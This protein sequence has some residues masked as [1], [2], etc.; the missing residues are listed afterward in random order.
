MA[1][2]CER[3]TQR[4]FRTRGA[5][6]LEAAVV[7]EVTESPRL[8]MRHEGRVIGLG[9]QFLDE[10]GARKQTAIHIQQG[11]YEQIRRQFF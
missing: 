3:R 8:V 1:V 9:A 7:A 11:A 4:A 2:V 6:D 10:N 5:G